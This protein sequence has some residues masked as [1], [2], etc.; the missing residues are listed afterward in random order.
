MKYQENDF[1]TN[2]LFA[3]SCIIKYRS[4]AHSYFSREI[5]KISSV[6]LYSECYSNKAYNIFLKTMCHC[7]LKCVNNF[8]YIE[9]DEIPGFLQ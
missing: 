2:P 8:Y 9:T 3:E 7:P 5:E 4:Y 1:W 6:Y